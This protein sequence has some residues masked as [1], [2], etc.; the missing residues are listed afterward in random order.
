MKYK[1]H[2][3]A[4]L[5]R[6]GLNTDT[7]TLYRLENVRAR[8]IAAAA[9]EL[10]RLLCHDKNQYWTHTMPEALASVLDSYG[11]PVSI[12]GAIGYLIRK[13]VFSADQIKAIC[14]D[15]KGD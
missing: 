2:F 12:A 15:V 11:A 1:N 7:E 10:G 14:S 13:G 5:P 4:S 9:R 3:I 6:I 8:E